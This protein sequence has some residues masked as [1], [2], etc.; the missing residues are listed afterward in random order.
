MRHYIDVYLNIYSIL[1]QETV[2]T[3]RQTNA[4]TPDDCYCIRGNEMMNHVLSIYSNRETDM[5]LT[6][7]SFPVEKI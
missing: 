4:R 3:I 6:E 7:T 2:F 5:Q 1:S